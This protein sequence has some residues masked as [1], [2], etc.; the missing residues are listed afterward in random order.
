M[1]ARTKAIE[2]RVK[3]LPE[4][5]TVWKISNLEEY[6]EEEI[7]NSWYTQPEFKKITR[8]SYNHALRW[9]SGETSMPDSFHRGLEVFTMEGE[10]IITAS[11]EQCID[12]VMDEQEAQWDKDIDDFDRLAAVSK[13]VS[14]FSTAYA[15]EL[16]RADEDEAQRMYT[17]ME[18]KIKS[19]GSKLDSSDHTSICSDLSHPEADS[20]HS[21]GSLS[22]S[23]ENRRGTKTRSKRLT[24]ALKLSKNK[25]PCRTSRTAC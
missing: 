12:A 4:N 23:I 9:E 25:F 24:K 22:E 3:F 5:D 21:R 17:R 1:N 18:Q 15:L 7:L 2:R 11:I 8:R 20:V 6:T 13:E 14:R 16:A 19:K 10:E